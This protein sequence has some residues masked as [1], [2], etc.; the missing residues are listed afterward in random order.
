MTILCCWIAGLVWDR[1]DP[2]TWSV[3]LQYETD[4]LQILGW[5][6]AASE[7]DYLPFASKTVDRLGA[8]YLANWND[9]PM[10]EEILTFLLGMVARAFGLMQASNLGI[11]LCY[12]P[13]TLAFYVCCRLMRYPR[14]WSFAGAILFGFTFYNSRRL[15][16]HLLLSFSYVI[17]FAL[18]TCWLVLGSKRLRL[19]GPW[20]CLCVGTSFL[21]GL[22]NPYSLNLFLQLFFFSL[23][24]HWL[25]HRDKERLKIGL[26]C[27]GVAIVGFI[28]VNLDTL[29]YGWA[30]GSNSGAIPRNYAQN[31]M[32]ALKP[33]EM[34]VPPANHNVETLAQIG[35]YY[36]RVALVKGELFSPYLGIVGLASLGWMTLEFLQAISRRRNQ[37]GRIAPFAPQCIWIMGYSVIG[38]VNCL[39]ALGGLYLFR[40]TN[41]YSIFISAIC[42]FFLVSRMARLSQTWQPGMRWLVALGIMAI[43][44]FDE[45]P[46]PQTRSQTL[47]IRAEMENDATFGAAM[48]TMLPEGGMVFQLPVMRFPEGGSV[49]AATD[50]SMLRPYFYT[51]SL[52]FSFGSEQGRPREDW[53][54]I[55]EKMPPTEMVTTLEKYGFGAIYINRRGFADRAESLVRAVAGLG[56]TNF[57]EDSQREQ[58]CIALNP[59]A[60]PE[61]PQTDNNALISYKRGWIGE[62]RFAGQVRHWADGDATV[63]F[64]NDRKAGPCRFTCQIVANSPRRVAIEFAGR[65]LWERELGGWQAVAADVWIDAKHGNNSLT[66]RTDAPPAKP[67]PNANVAVSF[68]VVNMQIAKPSP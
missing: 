49:Y 43:G 32:S 33:M 1:L 46:K 17:P 50:Y 41:R 15:I 8:P 64:F 20:F 54:F 62:E 39:F 25:R 9:Y 56:K 52:R 42:C 18:L 35:R 68:G 28:L 38:G 14:A 12:V 21:M 30:H 23:L 59:S 55:V 57:V 3:P 24:A 40:S 31:E 65:K 36:E 27:F 66:F 26:L 4:T 16:F 67:D 13:S 19:R 6:K 44:L 51:K 10:Y 2:K 48:E 47:A 34:V 7:F 61:L 60:G 5:I 53:Q 45:L 22:S 37:G 63:R 11:L 58:I 29:G